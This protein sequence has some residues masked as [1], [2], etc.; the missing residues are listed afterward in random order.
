M[1]RTPNGQVLAVRHLR[2]VVD[3]GELW[4]CFTRKH[5]LVVLENE[6]LQVG[7]FDFWG[8]GKRR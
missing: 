6:L 1:T 8:P 7:L 4:K 3:E 2:K 5:P